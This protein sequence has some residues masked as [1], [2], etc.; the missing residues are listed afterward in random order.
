MSATTNLPAPD[1]DL[2]AVHDQVF[3]T[4]DFP[5]QSGRILPEAPRGL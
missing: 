2:H 5:L 3:A 4:R 1:G